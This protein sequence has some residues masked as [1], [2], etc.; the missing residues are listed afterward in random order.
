[1][2]AGYE[3]PAQGEVATRGRP[4]L[5]RPE[6][7]DQAMKLCRL[8]ATDMEL[9]DFFGVD[10]VT[11]WRWSQVHEDFCNALKA[12][13]EAGDE[14]VVRSLYAKATGYTFD[15]VKIL[16][17][18]GAPVI[19]PY[20]EH[21]PPSDTAAIFW[22]KNRRPDE[23]REKATTEHTGPGGGPVQLTWGDGSTS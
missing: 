21:V 9:G 5:Y 12:G 2:V 1:M 18:E 7:A 15:A 13:K 10:R 16:Q 11:I 17:H 22:L 6:Y 3:P 23:W 8:G 19:V 4:T 14:R 20:R